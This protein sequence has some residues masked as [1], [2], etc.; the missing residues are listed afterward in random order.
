MSL[1]GNTDTLASKPKNITNKTTFDATGAAIDLTGETITVST[2]G[3]FEKGATVVYSA[4]GGTAIGGLVDGTT[5]YAIPL[6]GGKVQLASSQANAL[7][8][9]AINLTALGVGVA[10]SLQFVASSIYFEDLTEAGVTANRAAG[11]RTPGWNKFTTYTDSSGATRRK[12][13]TLIP[14]KRTAAAAGDAADDAVLADV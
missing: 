6:A 1:W 14:M 7:A 9:T 8:G 12:V 3:A 4:G 11:L 5:Y 10:H 2:N 13:E